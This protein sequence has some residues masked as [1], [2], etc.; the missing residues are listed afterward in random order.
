MIQVYII[1]ALI[2]VIILENIIHYRERKDLYNRIMCGS[3]KEYKQFENEQPNK[4]YESAH[5]KVL[6]HWQNKQ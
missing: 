3:A 6:K 1:F 5:R 4:S 2:G